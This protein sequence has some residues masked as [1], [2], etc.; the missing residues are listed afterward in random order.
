MRKISNVFLKA[1][2]CVLIL[3]TLGVSVY[4][5]YTQNMS[6]GYSSVCEIDSKNREWILDNFSHCNTA[7]ELLRAISDFAVNNFT[8]SDR[9]YFFI[10]TADFDRFVF[11]DNFH[12]VCFEFAVFAKTVATVWAEEKKVAMKSY[13]CNTWYFSHS[14][15]VGHSY[16]F[17]EVGDKTLLLDLTCDVSLAKQGQTVWGPAIVL[18]SKEEYNR[19]AFNPYST[20]FI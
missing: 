1:I 14:K 17:F 5:C 8:Y 13:I 19:K 10:Q 20:T 9:S 3:A 18:T 2:V 6:G 7:V 12:G 15:Q 4:S 16:N 11:E